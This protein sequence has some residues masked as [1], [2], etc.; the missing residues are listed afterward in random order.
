MLRIVCPCRL[1]EGRSASPLDPLR[2]FKDTP[3]L[4]RQNGVKVQVDFA[5]RNDLKEHCH[6][7]ANGNKKEPTDKMSINSKNCVPEVFLGLILKHHKQ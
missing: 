5:L 3:I 6:S 1:Q 7:L 4:P 2:K